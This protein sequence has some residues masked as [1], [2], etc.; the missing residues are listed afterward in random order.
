M[1]MTGN[2]ASRYATTESRKPT[3]PKSRPWLLAML[4]TSMP[5]PVNA[6]NAL[7]GAR[8]VYVLGSAGLG[9]RGGGC[10]R[11]GVRGDGALRSRRGA[12]ARRITFLRRGRPVAL[13][14]A[15]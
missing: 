2:R 1:P 11:G 13:V 9:R 4:A 7:A 8:N 12:G 3:G 15:R 10:G 5:A 14:I 6:V